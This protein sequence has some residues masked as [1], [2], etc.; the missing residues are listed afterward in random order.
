MI[1]FLSSIGLISLA[2][3]NSDKSNE[4]GSS[5]SGDDDDN[6]VDDNAVDFHSLYN[7]PEDVWTDPD[8][9]LIWQ[10]WPKGDARF[11][12]YTAIE[13]C[14]ELIYGGYDDW[15]LPTISELR[16]V[17][18]GCPSTQTGGEC[19]VTDTCNSMDCWDD[20][21]YY[22]CELQ[23]GPSEG[24]FYWP[25]GFSVAEKYFYNP[26]YLSSTELSDPESDFPND[27]SWCIVFEN[28]VFHTA[29]NTSA[30]TARCVR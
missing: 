17:I 7:L 25:D 12:Y 22:G 13:H 23:N 18:R 4:R 8:S 15:R 16:S 10:V 5:D 11:N 1:L 14:D 26:Y 3:D 9:G 20:K 24:G 30:N 28:A 29:R 19:G 6:D 2:C 21:C 27:H